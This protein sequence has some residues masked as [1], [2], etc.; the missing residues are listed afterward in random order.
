MD[1]PSS[2]KVGKMPTQ[3]NEEFHHFFLKLQLLV[4]TAT[5][6]REAWVVFVGGG[7]GSGRCLWVGGF[8]QP[9]WRSANGG[10]AEWRGEVV[11]RT[12]LCEVV[13]GTRRAVDLLSQRWKERVVEMAAT[14]VVLCSSLV[15]VDLV[16]RG[17]RPTLE[18]CPFA[19]HRRPTPREGPPGDHEEATHRGGAEGGG[20]M[21]VGGGQCGISARAGGGRG[22][23]RRT[24]A[25][26]AIRGRRVSPR[27]ARCAAVL[28][29]HLVVC[30]V[31]APIPCA[32]SPCCCSLHLLCTLGSG[33]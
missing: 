23:R 19:G 32:A 30:G 21:C 10:L 20:G 8:V 5:R 18:L 16:R 1:V 3:S 22:A 29:S 6:L 17:F 11:H 31:H 25:R 12:L 27:S 24:E 7:G 14:W 13:L 4:S 33:F 28:R 15:R 9:P 26:S 2:A